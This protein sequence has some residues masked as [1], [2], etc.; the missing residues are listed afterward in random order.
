MNQVR[1]ERPEISGTGSFGQAQAA[2]P[3]ADPGMS[4]RGAVSGGRGC[5]FGLGLGPQL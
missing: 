5:G 2:H 1:V 4:G 3:S